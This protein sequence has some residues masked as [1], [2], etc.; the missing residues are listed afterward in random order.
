MESYEQLVADVRSLAKCG[1]SV[2][3]IVERMEQHWPD[4]D[5]FSILY[6]FKDAFFLDVS[7]VLR[8]KSAKCC[9]SIPL[10]DAEID[11]F[12]LPKI[13]ATRSRW[14]DRYCGE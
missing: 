13:H 3:S 6:T 2:R 10:S 14:D 12:L 4:K 9:G 7:D 5:M 1:G 8:L 11:A